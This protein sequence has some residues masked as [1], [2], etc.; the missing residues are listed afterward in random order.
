LFHGNRVSIPQQ[1]SL[2]S[3]TYKTLDTLA[4][5]SI[6][7]FRFHNLLIELVKVPGVG[8]RYN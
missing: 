8:I 3:N 5:N 1:G 7:F 2:C 6:Y 4:Y